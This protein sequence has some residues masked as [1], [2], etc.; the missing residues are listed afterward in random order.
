MQS[1]AA[2]MVYVISFLGKIQRIELGPMLSSCVCVSVCLCVCVC[3]V[4]VPQENG[5]R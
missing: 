4:C 3:R 5:L 1:M 2:A